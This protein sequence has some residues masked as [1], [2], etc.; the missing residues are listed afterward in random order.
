MSKIEMSKEFLL[1]LVTTLKMLKTIII[2]HGETIRNYLDV[3][4]MSTMNRILCQEERFKQ[5]SKDMT[6]LMKRIISNEE[7]ILYLENSKKLSDK[8]SLTKDSINTQVESAIADFQI[9][10]KDLNEKMEE[11]DN[12]LNSIIQS[13]KENN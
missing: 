6:K 1:F 7:F 8:L 3:R 12:T 2:Q 11:M 5:I 10:F 9:H 4:A 13:L